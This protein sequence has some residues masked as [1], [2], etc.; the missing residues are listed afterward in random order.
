MVTLCKFNTSPPRPF[1]PQT[2]SYAHQTASRAHKKTPLLIVKSSL[3]CSRDPIGSHENRNKTFALTST[4]FFITSAD[5]FVASKKSAVSTA[6][7][8]KPVGCPSKVRR[9]PRKGYVLP[10][11]T[12]RK[13]WPLPPA[14]NHAYADMH[15]PT[16]Y[17]IYRSSAGRVARPRPPVASPKKKE[18]TSRKPG[19]KEHPT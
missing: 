7:L 17:I 16:H 3:Q 10:R 6:P 18:A 2:D 11:S 5:F 13:P 19:A 9:Q 12:H 8:R 15:R 4:S 14:E 1:L